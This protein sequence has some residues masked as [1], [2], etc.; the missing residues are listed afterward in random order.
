M[1]VKLALVDPRHLEYRDVHKT[2][3]GLVRT[4]LSMQM[5]RLLEDTRLAD[6]EKIKLYR[7]TLNRFLKA[8]DKVTDSSL[9]PINYTLAPPPPRRSA[10]KRT[11]K[12][13]HGDFAWDE[14]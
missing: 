12:K 9:P 4:D 8:G 3:E 1:A 13:R 7:Q 14:W 5:K 6:D 11:K 10:R 2:S